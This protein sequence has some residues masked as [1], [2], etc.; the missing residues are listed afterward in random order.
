MR[1]R[2]K[3]LGPVLHHLGSLLL[4]L[5][6]LVLIP[7]FVQL[8][9]MHIGHA[10]TALFT[11][12]LPALS[13]LIMGLTLRRFSG[14]G[15]LRGK[16]AM[17][18][19]A[20]AWICLSFF[21][22]LPFTIAL[23]ISYLD[24]YFE[25]VS[26]FTTT[27]I[28]MLTGL[29]EMA[30]S[31]LFWR[32][33]LQ[34]LG[35]LGILTFFLLV[36]G[37]GGVSHRLFTAESH[38]IFSKRP[39]PSLQRTLKILWGI[40]SLF[41]VIIILL[42][43]VVGVDIFD[44]VTHGL[45]CVATGGFSPYDANVAQFREAGYTNYAAIEYI[46]ILGM[47]LG[48][49]NFLIHFRV[50]TGGIQALWN[51]MEI[52]IFWLILILATFLVWSNHIL[53]S[54]VSLETSSFRTSLFQVMSMATGTGY[55]TE[56][57]GSDFFPSFSR[58]LFLLLMV[59]GGCVGST[60]G[61]IKVL[62]IGVLFKLVQLHVKLIIWGDLSTNILVI[63]GEQVERGEARRVA[64]IFFAWILLLA[65][66]S[67]ITAFFAPHLG[68]LEAASGMFSALGN[69][70]PC[71]ISVQEMIEL[72]PVIKITYIIGMLAGRLEILPIFMLF[73]RW[74]WR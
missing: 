67:G 32:A 23:G 7:L 8:F 43:I 53:H 59:I 72:N 73:S 2:L 31:L 74:T 3:F 54:V 19:C 38:K 11:Y 40:Y 30:R 14:T 52:R 65:I 44:A 34:W 9:Y 22:A 6:V 58:L 64:A 51:N 27:G 69:I 33:L 24:A 20:L 15:N 10:E 26:G 17:L 37:A 42:L 21:S 63:D 68:P 48:G 12:T 70:G 16:G 49:I 46:L 57:I 66:G 56:Y 61:G 35:G 1:N 60:T 36:V 25:A 71:Y 47:L 28:T 4:V 50:M 62:R 55:S 18:V 39:A 29:D 41:T 45:T 13:A 5:S